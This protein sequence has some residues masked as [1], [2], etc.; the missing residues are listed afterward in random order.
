MLQSIRRQIN[1]VNSLTSLSLRSA[2]VSN[3]NIKLKKKYNHDNPRVPDL[4]KN[5]LTD[6]YVSYFK[7]YYFLD[8]PTHR[9]Q[10][11]VYIRN[12]PIP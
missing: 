1:L 5:S 8:P 10:S 9:Q 4:F 6:D 7:I 12:A 3:S 11:L 2:S